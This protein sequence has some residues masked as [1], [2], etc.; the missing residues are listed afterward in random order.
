MAYSEL[1][2][3]EQVG[4][5]RGLLLLLFTDAQKFFK[6]EVCHSDKNRVR[7]K[8]RKPREGR[9]A[10]KWRK[11]ARKRKEGGRRKN[12]TKRSGKIRMENQGVAPTFSPSLTPEVTR[13]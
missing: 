12:E 2:A 5:L 4:G 9:V 11:K 10:R 3:A 6:N 1:P 8:G 7:E 13:V